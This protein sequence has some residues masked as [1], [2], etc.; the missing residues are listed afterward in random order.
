MIVDDDIVSRTK[1]KM[2]LSELGICHE[3]EKGSSAIEAF[4]KSLTMKQ[5]YHL[6]CLDILMP[7][8]DGF[9]VLNE[10]K[11]SESDYYKSEFIDSP[12]HSAKFLMVT[13][14]NER[15]AYDAAMYEQCI[16]YIIKPFRK[17]LVL[18]KLKKAGFY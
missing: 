6:V 12:S 4:K 2:I 5:P 3:F 9:D 18:E 7:E 1:L 16:G 11:T 14:V 13:S 8:M 15:D 17:N 10:I